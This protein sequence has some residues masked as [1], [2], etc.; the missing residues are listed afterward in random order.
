MKHSSLRA[1]IIFC[2][3]ISFG[4]AYGQLSKKLSY[5]GMLTTT[6]NQLVKDGKY[7]LQFSLYDAQT[8]GKPLWTEVQKDVE[9]ENGTFSV[10]LGSVSPLD[11]SFNKPL[12][13]EMT[14]VSGPELKEAQV[15]SPRTELTSS[16]F[17]L[18]PWETKGKDISF[19]GGKVGVGT[20]KPTEQFDVNGT[21][22]AKSFVGDGSNLTGITG[23][24]GG[25]SNTGSTTIAADN[26]K[27]GKG[28]IALQTNGQTRMTVDNGG[29]IGIGT[30]TPR[31]KLEVDGNIRVTGEIHSGNSL[32]LDGSN[33]TLIAT[34]VIGQ[35]N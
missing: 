19:S 29:N 28:E 15:F 8:E 25:V 14:A 7:T 11:I 22:K 34:E 33:H 18:A 21:V 20:D 3:L 12:Y 32:I 24:T 9:V 5:N 13:V 30:K 27:D 17:S 1:L 10:L 16:P 4:I 6:S 31:E 2:L 26:D 23:G 35:P